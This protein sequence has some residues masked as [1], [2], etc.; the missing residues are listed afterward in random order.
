LLLNISNIGG[1]ST[2]EIWDGRQTARGQDR[3]RF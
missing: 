3:R 1:V 2:A